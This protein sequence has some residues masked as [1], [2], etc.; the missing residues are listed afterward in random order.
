MPAPE[1]SPSVQE[2][3]LL[4]GKTAIVT[5]I[6][7]G[8]GRSI[9]L[10]FARHGASV[11]L[12]ARTLD[13]LEAVAAE[14]EALG[15]NSLLAPCDIADP[16]SCANLVDQAVS[17]FGGLDVIVQNAHHEGDWSPALAADTDEWRRIMDIN[18]FGALNL[19]QHAVPA[20]GETGGSVVFVNS[21]AAVRFP[22]NMGAYS[23][24][25]AALAGLTR[26]LALELGPRRVRVNG[27]F[28][29]PVAGDN[30]F[31]LGQRAAEASGMTLD[32]WIE[33]KASEL[34]IGHLPTPDECAGSVLFLASELSAPVTGQH[35]SVNGGQWVS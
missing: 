31:G 24:S 15:G 26:T 16:A 27:V 13:R 21:G 8:M 9:A 28:L 19:V 12:G 32:E 11:V 2:G 10:R 22:V 1:P 6:G 20:M 34:P 17:R 30:L 29:G 14:I 23:S 25:K 3:Q 5:G 33:V 4:G 7:P 18:F 35:L